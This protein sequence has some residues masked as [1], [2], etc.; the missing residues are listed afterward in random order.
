[1]FEHSYAAVDPMSMILS[2]RAYLIWVEKNFPHVPKPADVQAALQAMS[3]E[4][5]RVAVGR[6]KELVAYGRAVESAYAGT[7]KAS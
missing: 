3:P 6:A 7:A 2:G 5:Q 1:M 4:E